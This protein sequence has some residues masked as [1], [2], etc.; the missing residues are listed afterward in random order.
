[1]TLK[2]IE[3]LSPELNYIYM[4]TMNDL[5]KIDESITMHSSYYYITVKREDQII[6]KEK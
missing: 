6:L 1:M 5:K 3:K 2:E 4:Y